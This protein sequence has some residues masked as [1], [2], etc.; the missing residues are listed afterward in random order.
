MRCL[1]DTNILISAGLFPE[2]IPAAALKRAILPPNTAMVCD[3]SLDEM[4]RVIS[5]KFPNKVE[6]LE[7]FLYRLLFTVELVVTPSETSDAEEGIRDIKDRPILRAALG[8][9]ADVLISGDKDF[10]E[11]KIIHPRIM[12]SAEFLTLATSAIEKRL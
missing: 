7:S 3:Y 2:S 1:L 9:N 8:A 6:V 4:H 12:S 10:L 11:S 5:K